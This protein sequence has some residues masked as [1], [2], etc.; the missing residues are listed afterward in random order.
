MVRI[1]QKE[2]QELASV[3][4]ENIEGNRY[5]ELNFTY[6]TE[7][8]TGYFHAK[9][10]LYRQ[11]VSYPEGDFKELTDIVPVW[12]EFHTVADDGEV[13]NDFSWDELKKHLI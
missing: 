11:T 7:E 12:V 4:L 10:M 9:L 5:D 13:L 1:S 6:E 3:L 2:Y 8:W